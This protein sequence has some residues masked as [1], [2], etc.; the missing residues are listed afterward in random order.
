MSSAG[1]EEEEDHHR[2]LALLARLLLR[3]LTAGLAGPLAGYYEGLAEAEAEGEAREGAVGR[4]SGRVNGRGGGLLDV[5]SGGAAVPRCGP[6]AVAR[7]ARRRGCWMEAQ[8]ELVRSLPKSKTGQ[9]KGSSKGYGKKAGGSGGKWGGRKHKQKGM[10][11]K[12]GKGGRMADSSNDDDDEGDGSEEDEDVAGKGQERW[13]LKLGAGAG[14]SKSQTGSSGSGFER[15]QLWVV[16]S[17]PSLQ[18]AGVHGAS[19][20]GWAPGLPSGTRGGASYGSGGRGRGR[21]RGRGGGGGRPSFAPARAA[22][23]FAVVCEAAWHGPS[24]QGMLELLPLPVAPGPSASITTS[25]RG[26]Q[27]RA[28]EC[29][30][31][32]AVLASPEAKGSFPDVG[33][34]RCLKVIA[35][36]GGDG[37]GGGTQA[38][39]ALRL[40]AGAAGMMQRGQLDPRCLAVARHVARAALRAGPSQG[41]VPR[42]LA[43]AGA[44]SSADGMPSSSSSSSSSPSPSTAASSV[45]RV[46]SEDGV[47][48]LSASVD[49]W[50]KAE[51][52]GLNG[53]QRQALQTF[54]A[55][56]HGNLAGYKG[57]GSLSSSSSS[58]SSTGSSA[59]HGSSAES[60]RVM[61]LEGVFGSGKSRTLT[62]LV[63]L[64]IWQR[65]LAV[66]SSSG[67]SAPGASSHG[68]RRFG[69]AVGRQALY[70]STP[71]RVLVLGATNTAVDRVLLQLIDDGAGDGPA[72]AASLP[73]HGAG[74]GDL[75]TPAA[76]R[77]ARV[78]S[79]RRVAKP[80]LPLHLS[81]SDESVDGDLREIGLM[82]TQAAQAL[83]AARAELAKVPLPP[84][85]LPADERAELGLPPDGPRL[86]S[87]RSHRSTGVPILSDSSDSDSDDEQERTSDVAGGGDMSGAGGHGADTASR[88][89][90]T[91]PHFVARLTLRN[92][93]K[94]LEGELQ[95]LDEALR[96]AGDRK[97]R[98]ARLASAD[99]VGCTLAAS[100][101]EVLQ[102]HQFD[103]V[104][105]DEASQVVEGVAIAP[106]LQ[107]GA[108]M[109]VAAGDSNQLPPVVAGPP[110]WVQGEHE[111]GF[112]GAS[113]ARS[114]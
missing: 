85:G 10:W 113:R 62:A 34:G 112:E 37:A 86:L 4:A 95:H 76:L 68:P 108:A 94:E 69:K 24:S 46:G 114:G 102:G 32:E 103:L 65:G 75:H 107:F 15:G 53:D 38:V 71:G 110:R 21:G 45:T 1:P 64:A 56:W 40:I 20:P 74:S 16:S 109:L 51:A 87:Q 81:A 8:C 28:R 66:P 61:C 60:P 97:R 59:S 52:P 33:S 12:K 19:S 96:A 11:K 7:A 70:G 55:L 104:V 31:L 35:L 14:R 82:R 2:H 84:W 49:E 111:Q 13:F 101:F 29:L 73:D 9:G 36:R 25:G 27:H 89:R 54:A 78:G 77:V 6:A 93:V 79:V 41:P 80:L 98:R 90:R 58:S 91:D 23:P 88:S 72:A 92:R 42:P 5:L 44:A 99:V 30:P 57:P 3:E 100:Q 22:P 83:Q 106:A 17:V 39:H 18:P 26:S 63:R 50:L 47:A 48:G 67:G 105:L 43:A